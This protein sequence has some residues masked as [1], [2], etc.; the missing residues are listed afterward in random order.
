MLKQ[1]K[2]RE[3]VEAITALRA[4]EATYKAACA[5]HN[6][7]PDKQLLKELQLHQAD[8][9]PY[10]KVVLTGTAVDG[11]AVEAVTDCLASYA[12]TAVHCWG[13]CIG[14]RGLTSIAALIRG[15][16]GKWWQGCKLSVL[17]VCADGRTQPGQQ[18]SP[19]AG[20]PPTVP[21]HS[22]ERHA[23]GGWAILPASNSNVCS[24]GKCSRPS[25]APASV[26]PSSRAQQ[27]HHCV[28]DQQQQAPSAGVCP[29][30]PA[31]LQLESLNRLQLAQQAF[32]NRHGPPHQ[33][34]CKVQ[35]SRSMLEVKHRVLS[36]TLNSWRRQQQQLVDPPAA[37]R[38]LSPGQLECSSRSERQE[39]MVQACEQCPRFS[40]AA[41]Q[42]LSL[43]LGVR[44][45][46]LVRLAF[47][48]TLLGDAGTCLLASGLGNCSSLKQLSLCYCNIGPAG[49]MALAAALG[50]AGSIPAV[51]AGSRAITGARLDARSAHGSNDGISHSV[52][53]PISELT[54][55]QSQPT[56]AAAKP[57][58]SSC[59][60][61]QQFRLD[62]N[63]MLGAGLEHLNPALT[64]M[65]ALEV[66]RWGGAQVG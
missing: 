26:G 24:D 16:A 32:N 49:A 46:Q 17:E 47:D 61:L 33:F 62:G 43:A 38:K 40:T 30:V 35:P 11:A 19:S 14:D 25:T 56:L 15:S 10:D 3:K 28:A 65:S 57:S 18:W 7:T 50:A 20:L 55:L 22:I 60:Q 13:C 42:D 59:P 23:A 29:A 44:G 2:G 8:Y 51:R 66:R 39:H 58:S 31:Y 1:K 12:V 48:H 5:R 45:L 53:R 27:A 4:F 9:T 34:C 63:Q 64:A 6:V 36:S 21:T 52:V 37:S 54:K 41:L